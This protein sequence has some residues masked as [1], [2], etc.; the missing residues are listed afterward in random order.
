MYQYARNNPLRYLDPSGKKVQVSV[1]NDPNDPKKKHITLKASFA[2]YS[3][4]KDVDKGKLDKAKD[5]VKQVVEGSWKGSFVKKGITYD[6]KTEVTVQVSSSKEEA[7]KSGA[8]NVLEVGVT[9]PGEKGDH[10]DNNFLGSKPDF[11]KVDYMDLMGGEVGAHE[12]T[13][14]MGVDDHDGKNLSNTNGVDA[15]WAMHP[16]QATAQDFE[17]ALGKTID[18][19]KTTDM[20]QAGSCGIAFLCGWR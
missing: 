3:G 12:F 9:A 2:I 16:M 5:R 8:G 17:W 14:F 19:G 13:H 18:S 7:M 6:V 15:G 11:G 4:N 20:L 10:V 1:T